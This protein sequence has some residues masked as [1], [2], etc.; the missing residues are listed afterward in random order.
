MSTIK[1]QENIFAILVYGF[2]LLII[3][4]IGSTLF[5]KTKQSILYTEFILQWK[6]IMLD[7]KSRGLPLPS[8]NK[9]NPRKYMNDL[10]ENI[11]NYNLTGDIPS[12]TYVYEDLNGNKNQVF[13][14]ADHKYIQ[15]YGLTE[16]MAVSLDKIID[17]NVNFSKGQWKAFRSEINNRYS[18]LWHFN[19]IY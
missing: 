14:I 7:Y 15:V 6:H 1:T 16:A 5:V 18:A 12:Y 17:K 8:L 3:V 13:V 19:N 2:A 11:S 9:H 4:Y 10:V